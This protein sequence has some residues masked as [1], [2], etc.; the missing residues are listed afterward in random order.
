MKKLFV[1]LAVL[2]LSACTTVPQSP[3]IIVNKYCPTIETAM[4]L[5]ELQ[6]E[7]SVETKEKVAE[8]KT[9]TNIVCHGIVPP[10]TV[11][12][13]AIAR[14][15]IPVMIA[16]VAESDLADNKKQAIILTLVVAQ[17]AMLQ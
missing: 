3:E 12:I 9:L 7:I 11:D 6:P 1:V 16:A 8:A 13:D 2:L 10:T 4:V 17:A 14:N 5:I 15:V